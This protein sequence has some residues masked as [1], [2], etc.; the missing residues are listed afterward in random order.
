MS[1]QRKDQSTNQ[2]KKANK[3]GKRAEWLA[4]FS[5][6]LKGYRIVARGMRT[7]SGEIDI[8]ARKGDLVAVVEVKYRNSIDDA[9]NAVDNRSQLRIANAAN[10]WLSAQRDYDKLSLRFDIIAVLPGK[11][12]KHFVG[13]F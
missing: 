8:I 11:W 7:K 13:A 5:L 2:R 6:R 9:L 3:R 12:P 1:I 10:I 4:A